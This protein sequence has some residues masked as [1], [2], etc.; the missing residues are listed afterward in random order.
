M[1]K[2]FMLGSVIFTIF[3]IA[4]MVGVSFAWYAAKTNQGN[5]NLLSEGI[6]ITLNEND[7]NTLAPSVLREGVVYKDSNDNYQYPSD[8]PDNKYFVSL[9]N[10]LTYKE[11]VEIYLNNSSDESLNTSTATITFTISYKDKTG[12]IKEL[13]SSEI[14]EYF[15]IEYSINT[16]DEAEFTAYTSPITLTGSYDGVYNLHLSI[17]YKLPDELLPSDLVNSE[18]IIISANAYIN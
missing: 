17:S 9:G 8:Y 10:T 3:L 15:L 12:S 11:T 1:K 7:E 13:D 5:I 2:N 14:V 6:T 16:S 4:L 18:F